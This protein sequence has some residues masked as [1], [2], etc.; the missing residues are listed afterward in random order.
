[1]KK[2]QIIK[3]FS[4]LFGVSGDTRKRETMIEKIYSIDTGLDEVNCSTVIELLKLMEEAG[5]PVEVYRNFITYLYEMKPNDYLIFGGEK[6]GRVGV[7]CW[8]Y[9]K[10]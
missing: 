8:T 5:V 10:D 3:D 2:E 1:M 6:F 9:E 7:R 4:V